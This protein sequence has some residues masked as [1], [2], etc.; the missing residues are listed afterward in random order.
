[1]K[2]VVLGVI[3]VLFVALGSTASAAPP[4]DPYFGLQWGI[5]QINA[6]EASGSRAW[7]LTRSFCP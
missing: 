6:D 3:V 5:Q 2:S 4:N 7:H 1:M